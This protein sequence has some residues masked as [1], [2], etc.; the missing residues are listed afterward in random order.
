MKKVGFFCGLLALLGLLTLS[1]LGC[2]TGPVY[3]TTYEYI[4][5]ESSEGKA[6]THQCETMRVQCERIEDMQ[7]ERQRLD[8]EKQYQ[9]CKKA[10]AQGAIGAFCVDTSVFMRP[11]YT[12]CKQDYRRCFERCGGK[13]L[14]RTICVK[15]CPQT[16]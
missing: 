4:P 3:K 13:V 11:D 2:A 16:Q 15:N 9:K 7:T 14:E 8:A 12:K 6:C 5:P 1:L 10:Q